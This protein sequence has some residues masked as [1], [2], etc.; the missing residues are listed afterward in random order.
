MGPS[1][2]APG[3]PSDGTATSL[4]APESHTFNNVP[5]DFCGLDRRWR[6]LAHRRRPFPPADRRHPDA[7]P[8]HR[9]RHLCADRAG[10]RCQRAARLVRTALLRRSS[11]KTAMPIRMS[12]ATKTNWKRPTTPIPSTTPRAPRRPSSST[13][14]S[15]RRPL[16]PLRGPSRPPSPTTTGWLPPLCIGNATAD[17]SV[18]PP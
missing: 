12:M 10:Q 6:A 2:A 18:P 16:R 4:I 7:R 3:T 8:P 14:P 15:H 5:L 1:A 13:I 11:D 9:H 17:W